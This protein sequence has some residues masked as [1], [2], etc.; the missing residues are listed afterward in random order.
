MTFH[1]SGMFSTIVSSSMI[2]AGSSRRRFGPVAGAPDMYRVGWDEVVLTSL[3]K[4]AEM[5]SIKVPT[6]GRLIP[7]GK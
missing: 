5:F 1:L 3:L 4:A 2:G 6:P 7:L